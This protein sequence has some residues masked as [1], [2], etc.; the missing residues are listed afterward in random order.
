M[1]L[2]IR[3]KLNSSSII[4]Q[5]AVSSLCLEWFPGYQD[6]EY[7]L[8]QLIKFDMIVPIPIT[9]TTNKKLIAKLIERAR[10]CLE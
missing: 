1:A 7:R 9:T 4:A 10:C 8:L 5:F 6:L 2:V 3:S